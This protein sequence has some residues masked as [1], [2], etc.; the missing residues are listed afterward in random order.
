MGKRWLVVIVL[1]LL[2]ASSVE[3]Q[4]ALRVGV[5]KVDITP[6]KPVTMAGYG[7]RKDLSTSVHDPLSARALVFEAGGEHLVLVSTDILGFYDFRWNNP[8][9]S[10]DSSFFHIHIRPVPADAPN[11]ITEIDFFM[12]FK[13][14]ALVSIHNIGQ[15]FT[16]RIFID[17]FIAI[18]P[19]DVAKQTDHGRHSD[20]DMHV[21]RTK[22]KGRAKDIIQFRQKI[23]SFCR[24]NLF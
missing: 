1:S 19:L 8:K 21:G 14:G 4:A 18:Q 16:S 15:H 9:R 17:I 11:F 13:L 12:H 2:L 5:A 20:K 6:G 22:F 24:V 3:V 23:S 7:S 10:T